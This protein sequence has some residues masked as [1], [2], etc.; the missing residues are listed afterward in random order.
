MHSPLDLFVEAVA[1]ILGREE[2]RLKSLVYAH[3]V[4]SRKHAV[5][6]EARRNMLDSVSR[7]ERD[8]RAGDRI[9]EVQVGQ[10]V[11]GDEPTLR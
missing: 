9:E 5:L 7:R 4:V 11:G 8:L 6:G 1:R 3:D 10:L 2:V